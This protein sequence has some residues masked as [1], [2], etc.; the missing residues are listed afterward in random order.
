MEERPV[1]AEQL[2]QEQQPWVP[3]G[4][5]AESAVEAEQDAQCAAQ[6][7]SP[8]GASEGEEAALAPAAE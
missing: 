4:V 1:D 7:R 3:D 5:A 6:L 8:A 2:A